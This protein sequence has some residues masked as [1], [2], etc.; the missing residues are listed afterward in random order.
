MIRINPMAAALAACLLATA[1]SA[2]TF[3]NSV[4]YKDTGVPNAVAVTTVASIEARA[5]LNRNDTTDIEITTGSFEGD[6]PSGYVTKVKVGIPTADG[7]LAVNFNHAESATFTG[8][9][10][11]VIGGDVVTIDAHVRGLNEGTDRAT[12]QATVARRPD[13]SVVFVSTPTFAVKGRVGH[14]R[15]AIAENNGQLGARANVR[16][17]IDGTE[18]DR[19]ENVWVNAGGRVNVAFAPILE[20]E[21]GRHDFT[22]VV[23]S[24]T[25]GDWD[26][27]NNSRTESERVYDVLDE[28]YSWSAKASEREFDNYNYSTRSWSEQTVHDQGVEQTFR[29]QGTILAALNLETLTLTATGVTDGN[30]LFERSTTE[31]TLFDTPV[32][33]RCAM[34]FDSTEVTV[35][36]NLETE[37]ISVDINYATADATYRSWGW[38]TRQNPFAPEEPMYTF[39]TTRE[40]HSLQSRFGN[41]VALSYTLSDG[42]NHWTVEPFISSLSTSTSS[43]NIPYRCT[44]NSFTRETV[45]SERRNSSTTRSGSANGQA[46]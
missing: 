29:L 43:T 40:E 13:L 10:T 17:L 5:L 16:L 4:K 27:S 45:C 46:E 38:R 42:T 9:I 25:P 31:F 14:V 34:S 3:P 7:V 23:D 18:V 33:S 15:T 19:A 36:R 11:G 37:L 20:A 35:C 1:V 26:E 21:D 22:V 32:N 44:F 8:N 24:V 30:P 2:E 28:F 6:A 39:D 41:T 12:A